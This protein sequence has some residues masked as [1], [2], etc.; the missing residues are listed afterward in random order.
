MVARLGADPAGRLLGHTLSEAP[1]HL[2]MQWL[3]R[4]AVFEGEPLFGQDD[5]IL[6]ETL[7]VMP[8]D[9]ITRAAAGLLELVVTPEATYNL[10]AAALLALAGAAAARLAA[11]AGAGKWPAALAALLVIWSPSL[12]GFAADGRLDSMGIGWVGMLAVAWIAAMRAPSWRRGAAM[13]GW[14]VGVVFSGPNATVATALA[15]AIPTAAAARRD[16]RRI[17]PLLIATGIAGAAAVLTL[18]TLVLVE[19]NDSGRL[20]QISN[21][22]VQHVFEAT[23]PE[24]IAQNR[25]ADFWVGARALNHD[26]PVGSAWRLPPTLHGHPA[27]QNA[28]RMA[29]VQPYAPGAWWGISVV[30]WLL[31]LVALV[32]APRAAA[33]WVALA[34]ASLVLGLGHGSSQTLPLRIGSQLYYIAP[35][36]LIERLPVLSAFNNYGLFSTFSALAVAVAAAIGAS[37]L[38]RPPL[39]VAAAALLWLAE[40]QRGPV[41]L[42]LAVND[43]RPPA[44]LLEALE[45]MPAEQAVMMLPMSKDLNNYLQTHHH[46]PTLLR[47]RYAD[48]APGK[49]PM[50]ADPNGSAS[51]LLDHVRGR[52]TRSRRLPRELA[53]GGVGAVVAVPA[54]LPPPHDEA[55]TEALRQ[56]LGAPSWSDG[57]YQV[58]RLTTAP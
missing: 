4:R 31:A 37:R 36:V 3:I 50:L 35:A 24:A 44:G 7:W 56:A 22:D 33:P 19:R 30:P 15:A 21:E 17:R 13:G 58:Y 40:V 2:W 45:G 6:G 42:P 5:I 23:T 46:H 20:E 1:G 18:T 43:M 51:A 47:F 48:V 29:V 12:L 41:P 28:A 8:L 16:P 32:R 26:V 11:Q 39:V 57:G 53:A 49:D 14:A 25:L 54:L 52:S 55:L 9:W 34:A 27:T 38:P 10:L